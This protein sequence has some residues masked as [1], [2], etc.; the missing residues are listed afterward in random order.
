LASVRVWIAAPVA[1]KLM[2][3]GAAAEAIGGSAA[4]ASNTLASSA[5]RIS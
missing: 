4:L 5:G 3:A 2:G 1:A